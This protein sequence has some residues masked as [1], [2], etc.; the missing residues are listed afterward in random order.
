MEREDVRS[1]P[2][3]AQIRTCG[4]SSPFRENRCTDAL[5]EN[6]PIPT[7]GSDQ[8]SSFRE[9]SHSALYRQTIHSM[10]PR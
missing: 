2:A 6:R 1:R 4:C 7:D 8:V 3:N 9:Q 5:P 10:H